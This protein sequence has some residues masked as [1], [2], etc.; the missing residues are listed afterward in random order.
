MAEDASFEIEGVTYPMPQSFRLGDPVLVAEL[1]GMSWMQF[2]DALDDPDRRE[3]P[4]VL[5]GL[6]AVAVWQ[7]NARWTRERCARYVQNLDIASVKVHAGDDDDDPPPAP[8]VD[9]EPAAS[10]SGGVDLSP[11]SQSTSNGSA[12]SP[13]AVTPDYSGDLGS[14]IGSVS[15]PTT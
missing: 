8:G 1:T 14:V 2:V 7:G 15:L 11:P 12:E 9:P 5:L 3:D 13:S 6:I 4:V 10:D